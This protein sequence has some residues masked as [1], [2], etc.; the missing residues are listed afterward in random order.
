MEFL[1]QNPELL[2]GGSCVL[3]LTFLWLAFR[4]DTASDFDKRIKRVSG[5]QKFTIA[6]IISGQS[7]DIRA[8]QESRLDY[9][10]KRIMPK[11]DF[12]H[13]KLMRTGKNISITQFG[14]MCFF[15]TCFFA[16]IFLQ[17]LGWSPFVC[18]MVGFVAGIKAVNFV[19]NFMIKR[20]EK[21]FITTF[22]DAIDLMVRGIKSGLPLT[23]T[24]QS[25]A[26]EID[27]PVGV[28][29]T[30]VADSIKLGTDMVDALQVRAERL[31][32]PELKFFCIALSIQKETGG[33]LAETLGNLANIL[34]KRKQVKLKI[35][36]MSS[37]AKASAII[38]GSLP[39]V[40][41]LVLRLLNPEYVDPLLNDPRGIK[42]VWV[43]LGMIGFGSFVMSKMVSFEV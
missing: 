29:F 27:G 32:I 33:N 21:K 40:M 6:P 41:Y 39:F 30:K 36:A 11:P 3:F 19:I 9:I 17:K 13:R 22:P 7:V 1:L 23:Q 31:D 42:L 10:M 18:I 4:D 5:Q 8:K 34:R 15:M 35:K 2:Y 14:I 20:R 16:F 12:L 37:E 26:N 28:E 24:I 25:I 43:G 38:I